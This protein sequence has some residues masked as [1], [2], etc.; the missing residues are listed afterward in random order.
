[1]DTQ[2]VSTINKYINL[3]TALFPQGFG[4]KINEIDNLY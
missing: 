2:F 1:M 3:L 4:N